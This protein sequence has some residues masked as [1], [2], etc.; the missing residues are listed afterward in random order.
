MR[1]LRGATYPGPTATHPAA[2]A[3]VRYGGC[4]LHPR[5]EGRRRRRLNVSHFDPHTNVPQYAASASGGGAYDAPFASDFMTSAT[6][7]SLDRRAREMDWFGSRRRVVPRPAAGA[8]PASRSDYSRRTV[9][10]RR[11]RG[12]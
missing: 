11:L 8:L 7:G 9:T 12:S 4:P 6:L 10:V 2:A 5:A 3:R 1:A